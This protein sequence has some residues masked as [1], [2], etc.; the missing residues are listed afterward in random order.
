[1]SEYALIVCFDCLTCL[2]LTL[3]LS[4]ISR[5]GVDTTVR[6]ESLV[7][8]RV[9]AIEDVI[10]RGGET[11]NLASGSGSTIEAPVSLIGGIRPK[12]RKCVYSVNY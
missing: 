8:D 10:S 5:R 4:K 3:Y 2:F 12:R 6:G 11:S 9:S 1:M 7:G